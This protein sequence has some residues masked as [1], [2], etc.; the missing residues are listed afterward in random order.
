MA[1]LALPSGLKVASLGAPRLLPA[2]EITLVAGK[3][4]RYGQRVPQTPGP[5][6]RR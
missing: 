5:A 6:Q 4:A 1:A 3:M 2:D